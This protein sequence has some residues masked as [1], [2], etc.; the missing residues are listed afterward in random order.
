MKWNFTAEKGQNALH[1][2]SPR[3]LNFFETAICNR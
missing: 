3:D 1:W 2:E